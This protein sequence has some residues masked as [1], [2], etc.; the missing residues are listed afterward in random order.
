MSWTFGTLALADLTISTS[1]SPRD[2]AHECKMGRGDAVITLSVR[3]Y[4]QWVDRS[5]VLTVLEGLVLLAQLKRPLVHLELGQFTIRRLRHARFCH[6][7]T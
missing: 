2:T 3:A 1:G 7:H 4:R 6:D 5:W